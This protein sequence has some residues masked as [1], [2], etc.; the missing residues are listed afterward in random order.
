[1]RKLKLLVLLGMGLMVAAVVQAQDQPNP[2]YDPNYGQQ[3]PGYNPNY[4]P[5]PGYDPNYDQSYNQTYVD[6]GYAEPAYVGPPPVCQWGY[7]NYYPYACAPYGYYGPDWFADGVFIGVGPWGRGWGGWGHG[8]RGYY[9]GR[10]W[11]G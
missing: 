11:G 10:G 7:Y 6:P 8:W 4:G 2:Y 3:D 5:N 1:M 9:G